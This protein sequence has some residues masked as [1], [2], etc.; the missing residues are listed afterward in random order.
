[1]NQLKQIIEGKT[2]VKVET[3]S[4]TGK[5]YNTNT[6]ELKPTRIT[7]A[8]GDVYGFVKKSETSDLELGELKE[9]VITVEYVYRKVMTT[10]VDEEGKEINPSDKGTKDKK[11]ISGYTFKETKKDKDGNTIHV[12]RQ[13]PK[14]VETTKPTEAK[15][16]QTEEGVQK[17]PTKRLANTGT[18]ENNTGLAGLGLALFGG[19]LAVTK[20][21]KSKQINLENYLCL[22][23]SNSRQ[24]LYI[25]QNFYFVKQQR[26]QD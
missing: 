1:M 10:Y 25:T 22:S 23:L 13:N 17:V 2:S 4:P 24:Y 21:R 26:K 3:Q 8:N 18:T 20:R 9:G 15:T 14:P 12:Y 19:L 7:T 5:E 11:E 16:P 6:P